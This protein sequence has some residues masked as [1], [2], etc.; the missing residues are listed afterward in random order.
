MP[1][2]PTSVEWK[3]VVSVEE[4][5]DVIAAHHVVD[6]GCHLGIKKTLSKVCEPAL[7]VNSGLIC[8]GL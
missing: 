3:R 5:F 6:D 8:E 1:S 4:F 2:D 7:Y